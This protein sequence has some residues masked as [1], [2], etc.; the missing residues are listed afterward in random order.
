MG[1][2][3]FNGGVRAA[4]RAT[5][6][7][8]CTSKRSPYSACAVAFAVLLRRVPRTS[9]RATAAPSRRAPPGPSRTAPSSQ[10]APEPLELHDHRHR[11]RRAD[12]AA[13][14]RGQHKPGTLKIVR[15]INANHFLEVV[16]EGFLNLTTI[17][18][19]D[20]A[21]RQLPGRALAPLR[22][23]RP[24]GRCAV[25]RRLHGEVAPTSCGCRA[26]CTRDPLGW[27]SIDLTTLTR[28]GRKP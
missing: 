28:L 13:Q 14:S 6:K 12:G 10:Q 1:C 8:I 2:P 25:R 27:Q 18:D 26:V 20:A 22:R 23:A 19:K 24:A 15:A 3:R 11:S 16:N 9:R 7:G 5:G 21:K 17:Y 4:E